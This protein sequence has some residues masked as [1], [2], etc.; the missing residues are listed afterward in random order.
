MQSFIL[1]YSSTVLTITYSYTHNRYCEFKLYILFGQWGSKRN[2]IRIR[3]NEFHSFS[4]KDPVD[5]HTCEIYPKQMIQYVKWSGPEQQT[6]TNMMMKILRFMGRPACGSTKPFAF[7]TN[8]HVKNLQN[9]TKHR[10]AVTWGHISDFVRGFK[11]KSV[12]VLR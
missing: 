8:K 4:I 6:M 9:E 5:I 1:L 3:P 12:S 7:I 2:N 11:M 10:Q